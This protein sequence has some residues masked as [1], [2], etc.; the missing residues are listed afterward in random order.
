ME[1]ERLA[2]IHSFITDTGESEGGRGEKKMVADR[3]GE[4]VVGEDV[5]GEDR[6]SG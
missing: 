4:V 3:S 6:K 2:S 1:M 5:V